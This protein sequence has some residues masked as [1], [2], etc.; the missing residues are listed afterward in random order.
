MRFVGLAAVVGKYL[1][2]SAV[3]AAES[4]PAGA[5]MVPPKPAALYA[6]TATD[7][8]PKISTPMTS[9]ATGRLTTRPAIRPHTPAVAEPALFLVGQNTAQPIAAP[10]SLSRPRT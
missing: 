6:V 7:R 2:S 3:P 4:V 5:K 8:P 9:A 10:R 1:L